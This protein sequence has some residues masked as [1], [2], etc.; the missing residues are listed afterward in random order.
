[1][2]DLEENKAVEE[3]KPPVAEMTI[4]R[5][6]VEVKILKDKSGKFV[7]KNPKPAVTNE[8]SLPGTREMTIAVRKYLYE[9]DP[10]FKKPRY[11]VIAMKMYERA[12]DNNPKN[13]LAAAKQ[14]K[15]FL[16]RFI[17]AP[18][19]GDSEAEKGITPSGNVIVKFDMK[20][21]FPD[22]VP[23]LAEERP[24]RQLKQPTF[25]EAEVIETS[26]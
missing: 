7:S 12:I 6:G 8:E 24:R 2:P 13:A 18:E 4:S 23:A 26:K 10:E 25:A 16:D 5:A 15:D 1:M 21:F 20:D 14:A 3:E 19:P 17:G 22:G 9:V 11:M